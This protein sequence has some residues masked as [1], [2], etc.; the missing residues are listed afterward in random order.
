M[1]RLVFYS[2][3][4]IAANQQV[5]CYLLQ[6]L[7]TTAARIGYISSS[8][9][10][11][12]QYF[13]VK[14]QYYQQYG[15][16]LALYVELD[17]AYKTD[18]LTSLFACDAIHLSGGNT[19]YFLY[20]LQQRGLMERLQHYALHQGVLVGISAGAILMTP[21]VASAQLCGDTPYV[22]L[23]S[24]QGLGL[25]DFAFVPHVQDTPEEHARLQAYANSQQRV[26]YGCHDGDGIV[27]AGETV[28]LVGNVVSMTPISA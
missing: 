8:S 20:W 17:V 13:T 18:L 12:R 22:P 7:G 21:L 14:Q 25:V 26:L 16:E 19:Y 6:L 10:P 3:Q 5:D 24:Y 27:V 28:T 1:R 2:D 15:L 23:T 4:V 9:D 11:E